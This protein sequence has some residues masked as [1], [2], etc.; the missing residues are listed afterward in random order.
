MIS[1]KIHS[2]QNNMFDLIMYTTWILYILIGFGLSSS[3]PQY[4][5]TLQNYTKIYVSLFLLFRFNPFRKVEFTDLDSKIVFSAALFLLA[6][7]AINGILLMNLEKVKQKL[8]YIF[9]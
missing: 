1:K 3:A 5:D 2:F 6:T 4:L 7:T 8:K 9:M